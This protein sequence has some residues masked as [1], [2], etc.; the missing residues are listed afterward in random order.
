MSFPSGHLFIVRTKSQGHRV[1]LRSLS[2]NSIT[3]TLT[4]HLLLGR[5]IAGYKRM[6]GVS[7]VAGLLM[8]G[9]I[10]FIILW[11][12]LS[13]D[14]P[15]IYN[16]LLSIYLCKCWVVRW[17]WC[18]PI[19]QGAIGFCLTRWSRYDAD[20]SAGRGRRCLGSVKKTENQER[21]REL[22]LVMCTR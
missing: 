6:A 5:G 1:Y 2:N 7:V 15:Y 18:G 14:E 11:Y 8:A 22:G 17:R 4:C 10:K 20:G 13:H 21:N 3:T 9:V 19:G 12:H 16:I